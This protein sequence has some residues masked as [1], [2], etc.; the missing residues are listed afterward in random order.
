MAGFINIISWNIRGLGDTSKQYS[1]FTYIWQFNPAIICLLET[2]LLNE[3]TNLLSKPWVG[4]SY[5]SVYSSHA[6]GLSVLVHNQ[7]PFQGLNSTV[8]SDGRFICPL[9]TIYNITIVLIAI[10]IPPPYSGEIIKK[11]LSFLDASPSVPSI[12]IGDFNNY[13]RPYWDK[14]HTGSIDPQARPTSISWVV[15]EIGFR[16]LWRVRFP[17]VKQYSCYSTSH[18]ALS[19]IDLALG[20]D[21]MLPLVDLVE[22]LPR[23]ISDHSPLRVRLPLGSAVGLPKQPWRPNPFWAHLIDCIL[24][25]ELQEYFQFNAASSSQTL[26]WDPTKAVIRGLYIREICKR[27]SKSRELTVEL[28]NRVS[29]TEQGFIQNP[30]ANAENEWDEAHKLLADHM[31]LMAENK[32][33]FVRQ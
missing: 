28:Q 9:C 30:S 11:L 1:V 8:D 26:V 6:R 14:F 19:R 12:I 7:I 21:S 2:H 29:L 16:D 17:E 18:N 32:R 24:L 23:N 33:F 10:Y 15:D 25:K 22:Y 5:H 27:K 20:S 3:K 4:H 13:L 31:L